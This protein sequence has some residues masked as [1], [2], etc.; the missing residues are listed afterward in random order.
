[1]RRGVATPLPE[2]GYTARGTILVLFALGAA[3]FS[4]EIVPIAEPALRTLVVGTLVVS[5]FALF[6]T[7][8][9]LREF[10]TSRSI[11]ALPSMVKRELAYVCQLAVV[12]RGAGALMTPILLLAAGNAH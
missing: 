10:R 3:Y 8:R 1:M 9:I 7:R 2:L 5:P 12:V 11:G 6:T 4:A